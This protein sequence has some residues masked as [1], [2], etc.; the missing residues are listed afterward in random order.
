M[1]K[2]QS[3]NPYLPNYEYVPDGEP[4]IFEGRVYIYGSHDRFGGTKYCQNDY[5][6]WSAPLTDLKDWRFEGE[7]YSKKQHPYAEEMEELFAP[8]VVRGK[9]GKYYLY[10]S[11]AH[12][13]RMSGAVCDTPAGR[14]EYL[15]DMKTEDGRVYGLLPGDMYQ[16][17]P[18]VFMDDDGC[19][20]LYSGFCPPTK[21]VD[22]GGQLMPGCHMY[23]LKSDMLTIEYGPNLVI[24]RDFP[25]PKG[26]EYFE[27][28][29]LRKINGKYHLIYS[30]RNDGLH[31]A[32]SDYPDQDFMYA[33]RIH[34]TSDVGL[35]GYTVEEPCYP[36]GNTHGSLIELHGQYYIFDHRLTNKSSFCRQGVVEP[37]YFDE[38]GKIIQAEST[39]QGLNG[40]PLAGKGIYETYIACVLRDLYGNEYETKEEKRKHTPMHTQEGEDRECNPNQYVAE[41][42]NGSLIGFKYFDLQN[43][44]KLGITIRGNAEGRIL[45]STDLDYKDMMPK[46]YHILCEIPVAINCEAWQMVET[47]VNLGCGVKPLQFI[48]EGQGM[49]DFKEFEIA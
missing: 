34:S 5:V 40:G 2:K 28:P 13:S 47:C 25:C 48:F 49:F 37:V 44:T 18:G 4:H 1:N 23:K 26:A 9:D 45:V 27:A 15:G 38:N 17:D 35:R 20:Y 46:D 22:K 30:A 32:V 6:C 24:G 10:Y 41:A 16:F 39:S 14:Y 31:Y 8:D 29:S 43:T 11:V 12:S 33:G 21:E 36:V 7:I 3:F 42:Q 19:V